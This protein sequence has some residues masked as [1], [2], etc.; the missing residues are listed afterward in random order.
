MPNRNPRPKPPRRGVA[1][2]VVGTQVSTGV[3]Q[4]PNYT[5]NLC[6]NPSFEYGIQGWTAT[7]NGTTMVQNTSQ[8]LQDGTILPPVLIPALYGVASLLV[9]TDGSIPYQGVFGP[10]GQVPFDPTSGSMT[11][12]FFGETGSLLVSAVSNP[13]GI[14]MASTTLT[15]N[16]SNWQTVVF[17]NLT[18]PYGGQV[19]ILVQTVGNQ[20]LEFLIDGVMYEP[21]TPAHPFI[22]GDSLSAQWSG[23]AGNSTSFLQFQYNTQ[24]AVSIYMSGWANAVVPGEIF[25]AIP[26][27]LEFFINLTAVQPVIFSPA[28]ALTDFGIWTSSDPDPAMTYAWWTNAGSNNGTTSYNRSY[29]MVVPPLDYPVSG[30]QFA[31]RRAAYMGVGFRWANVSAGGSEILTDVQ[32]EY[33]RTAAY[34]TALTPGAYQHPRQLQVIIKPSRLNYIY[35][36]GFWLSTQYWSP[37]PGSSTLTYGLDTSQYPTNLATYDNLE[38]G[39]AQ[40]SMKVTLNSVS[41]T[42]VQTQV[43][44]LI[45]GDDYIVSFYVMP[46]TAFSDITG[47]LVPG[48]TPIYGQQDIAGLAL[49]QYEYGGGGITGYGSGP[50]GG[51]PASNTPLVQQWYRVWWAFTATAD[52]VNLQIVPSTVTPTTYPVSFWIAAVMLE[53]GDILGSYFDGNSGADAIWEAGSQQGIGRSFYYN[54]LAYGQGIVNSILEANTPLGISAATPLYGVMPTQ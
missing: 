40:Q 36:P 37:I 45:P 49:T 11:I 48:V 14:L 25:E 39:A 9:T 32:L 23:T 29:G 7:D 18:F 34:S 54:Q 33:A 5:T 42:G 24:S 38:F 1:R 12:S 17:D 53:P 47:Q 22:D 6:P 50:Y 21:E 8:N 16:G 30:G 20:A 44:N 43:T 2:H 31:W 26:E 4:D 13:G 41:D 27:D 46:T 52:T 28:A 15:L 19:Y 51:V 10:Y 3:Y 35:N